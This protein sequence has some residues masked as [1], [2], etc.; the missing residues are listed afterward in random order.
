MEGGQHYF[1]MDSFEYH[2]FT[3]LAFLKESVGASMGKASCT[4]E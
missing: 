4:R 2:M 3:V 1:R